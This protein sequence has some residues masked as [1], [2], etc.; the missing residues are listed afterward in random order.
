MPNKFMPPRYGEPVP[1]ICLECHKTFVGPNP[2]GS[3]ILDGLFTK[4]KKAKCPEC[5]SRKVARNP[6]I[7][8]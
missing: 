3:K 6:M 5:G 1:L 8:Y 2:S 7:Q 4:L